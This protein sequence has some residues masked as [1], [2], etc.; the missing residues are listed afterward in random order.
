MTTNILNISRRGFVS[1]SIAGTAALALGGRGLAADATKLKVGFISPR[2]G[3]LAGFGQ[4]DGY[5]LEKVRETLAKG[6]TLG[7]KAFAV[8]ILDRDT[9]SDPS[10][11]GQLAKDLINNDGID[12]MLVISTPEVINPVSD[13]CEAAGVPCLS[14]V[15][16][17]E[18]WYFGRGAKPGQ[19]SPFKWTYHFGFGV[20]EF[21][22][23]YV[24][25]WSLIETN[26]KVGVMYPNDADG[27]AIRAALAPKL[28]AAG[29]TIIDPGPYEDGTTD[30]SSQ[31]A[32]FKK[33]KVEIFNTFP[34]PP[35]FA[36]FWRQAAQQGLHKQVKIVQVAKTGL[37]PSDVEA[38]GAL[39]NKIAGACYWHKAFPYKS[40]LTGLSGT[41]LA[42]GYEAKTG[43]EWTQQLGATMSLFD[44]GFAALN[45]ASDAKDKASVAKSLAGL[46]TE[47]MIG[48]V[49]FTSGPF[50]NVSPGPIIGGQW[51][52]SQNTKFKYDFVI[53]ENA[54]DKN[55]P[56]AAKLQP[57]NG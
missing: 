30:Y 1:A 2:T 41:D 24:S 48:K 19:P 33:E 32:L 46:N 18:A 36:A 17:W 45:K 56:I 12:M 31:I 44:A 20:D 40:P 11:A 23:T 47:T 28:A 25:Q 8:E 16:P 9:Q 37:F 27:N 34:I 51:V 29:F 10:R 50:P 53:T 57:Y 39:G 7:G 26:K 21:Y 6:V 15:M 5:V 3:P 49:D 35:D 42:D 54:T 22:K 13:A 55:V 14:T 38:L 4:T 43:K 52:K